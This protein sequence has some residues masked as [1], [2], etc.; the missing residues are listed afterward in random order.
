MKRG[1]IVTVALQGDYG[2]PRPAVVIQS[3]WIDA[4]ESVLV[5]LLTSVVRDAPIFRL[6]P[7]ERACCSPPIMKAGAVFCQTGMRDCGQEVVVR[8]VTLIPTPNPILPG[9]FVPQIVLR[10]RTVK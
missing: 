8:L 1:D 9:P 7:H 3:D 5:C 10:G 2:K 6:T 4:T